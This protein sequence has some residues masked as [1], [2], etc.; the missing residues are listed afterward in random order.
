MSHQLFLLSYKS[1]L[2]TKMEDQNFMVMSPQLF[3]LSY[4]SNLETKMED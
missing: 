3:L 4:K 1:N 2:E